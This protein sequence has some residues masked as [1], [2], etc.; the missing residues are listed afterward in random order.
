MP[1]TVSHDG[2]ILLI[3]AETVADGRRVIAACGF[4]GASALGRV[5][6]VT[7]PHHLR[8]WRHGTPVFFTFTVTSHARGH[9]HLSDEM[10]LALDAMRSAG[11]LRP[12]DAAEAA[13]FL[14]GVMG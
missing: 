8:G 10:L 12:V 3:A 11:R 2:G 6:I 14:R 5:R 9:A 7:E 13:E 4:G 1:E